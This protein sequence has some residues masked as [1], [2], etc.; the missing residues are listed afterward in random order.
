MVL[1]AKIIPKLLFGNGIYITSVKYA[2]TTTMWTVRL[3]RVSC[4]EDAVATRTDSSLSASA[5]TDV[6]AV[7]PTDAMFE[8]ASVHCYFCFRF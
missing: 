2:G 7:T 6:E 1:K 3:A 8:Y 5:T 4:T